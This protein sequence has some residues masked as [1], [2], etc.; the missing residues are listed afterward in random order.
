LHVCAGQDVSTD[1]VRGCPRAGP[2]K[3]PRARTYSGQRR[4][5]ERHTTSFTQVNSHVEWRGGAVCKTVGLA[6]VGSNPTPATSKAARQRRCRRSSGALKVS[7]CDTVDLVYLK[8]PAEA[9]SGQVGPDLRQRHPVPIVPVRHARA[10]A[11]LVAVC[12]T[13]AEQHLAMIATGWLPSDP[14]GRRERADE[15]VRRECGVGVRADSL[16]CMT[17]VRSCGS[18][19]RIEDSWAGR[20]A[21]LSAR[22]GFICSSRLVPLIVFQANSASVATSQHA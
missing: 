3:L 15:A 10:A 19:W 6:Y 21:D 17:S 14:L 4:R 13:G 16:T 5:A 9:A 1:G 8:R 18:V 7:G 2:R 11:T 12:G 22:L 20:C